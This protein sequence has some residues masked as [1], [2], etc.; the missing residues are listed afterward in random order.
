[1]VVA[2]KP[3]GD[4]LGPAAGG[5]IGGA[6]TASPAVQGLHGDLTTELRSEL[7]GDGDKTVADALAEKDRTSGIRRDKNAN[8]ARKVELEGQLAAAVLRNPQAYAA[9][10]HQT[11]RH[12]LAYLQR[13]EAQLKISLR[14][15]LM[16]LGGQSNFF[17]RL[18]DDITGTNEP[19]FLA[20]IQ[21]VLA[22]GGNI[23][24][25][26][27]IHHQFWTKIYEE[28]DFVQNAAGELLDGIA[29]HPAFVR[30]KTKVDVDGVEVNP[31][32]K[33][34]R[35]RDASV[36]KPNATAGR[37]AQ[38]LGQN[39]VELVDGAT[40]FSERQAGEAGPQ[41]GT[42]T[43]L[44]QPATEEDGQH[45]HAAGLDQSHTRGVDMW[46]VNESKAF[47]QRARVLLD[48]PIAAGVSGTTAD[49]M[50][51]AETIGGVKSKEGKMQYGLAVLGF[52]GAAGAHSFH[53]I[54]TVVGAAG[55]QYVEGDYRGVYPAAFEA[56][57]DFAKLRAKY[58]ELLGGGPAEEEPPETEAQ[59]GDETAP[60]RAVV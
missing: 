48:M 10:V 60:R 17:G 33:D 39:K 43:L 21:K 2:G 59:G 51:C 31:F 5:A 18:M 36:N 44:S 8:N 29:H 54:L 7:G 35:G 27:L 6:A 16:Q 14:D 26:L 45:D 20:E 34:Q 23:P 22:G 46:T 50:G 24:N 38:E 15:S 4:L 49:L 3:A 56:T 19:L 1:R 13:R 37:A 53:E 58:P 52:L 11:S 55:G 9:P 40:G 30:H 41:A 57:A 12:I 42:A 47:T 25:H 32:D 28:Q